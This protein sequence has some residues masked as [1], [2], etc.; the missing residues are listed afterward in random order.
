MIVQENCYE[1]SACKET[2][3]IVRTLSSPC[4]EIEASQCEVF[5][6][7][8]IPEVFNRE[9]HA[10]YRS[11]IKDFGDDG[12]IVSIVMDLLRTYELTKNAM[13]NHHVKAF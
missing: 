12:I 1:Y 3:C 9:S 10:G 4:W 2:E 13:S 7:Y 8:V 11:P 5:S 6:I